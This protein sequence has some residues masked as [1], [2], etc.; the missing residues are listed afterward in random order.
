[1]SLRNRIAIHESGH[2]VVARALCCIVT[3]IT[4]E[5]SWRSSYHAYF[6]GFSDY[7]PATHDWLEREVITGI[8]SAAG[9]EAER[10]LLAQTPE[11]SGV[12]QAELAG[13]V[14]RLVQVSPKPDKRQFRSQLLSTIRSRA[15]V[16]VREH[17][18]TIEVVARALLQR[19]RLTGDELDQL[20]AGGEGTLNV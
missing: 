3:E 8:V 1:L 17:A 12:D 13:I 4:I 9:A 19:Q 5:R 15:R 2:G 7:T 11:G 10:H 14:D 18:A 20:M 16:L 6:D